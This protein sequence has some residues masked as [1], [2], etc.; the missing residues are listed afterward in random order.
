MSAPTSRSPRAIRG[1]SRRR[2]RPT[3]PRTAS[4]ASPGRR[5]C[6]WARLTAG[7]QT[8]RTGAIADTDDELYRRPCADHRHQHQSRADQPARA[9]KSPGCKETPTPTAV[10][11]INVIDDD[12]FLADWLDGRTA[13]IRRAA[14]WTQARPGQGRGDHECPGELGQ[15]RVRRRVLPHRDARDRSLARPG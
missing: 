11:T 7:V 9:S 1:R 14:R 5:T 4:T 13:A 10:W 6:R 12:T 2:L 15:Q 3:S 8:T